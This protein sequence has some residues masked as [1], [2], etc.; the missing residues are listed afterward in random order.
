MKGGE[1]EEGREGGRKIIGMLC[2][3]KS[4]RCHTYQKAGYDLIYGPK[5]KRRIAVSRTTWR[6]W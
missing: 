2:Y 3:R 5:P 4:R 1:E 6:L